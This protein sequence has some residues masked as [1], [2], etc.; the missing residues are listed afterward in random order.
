MEE[1]TESKWACLI[2][3][4]ENELDQ[5]N[6]VACNGLRGVSSVN[7]A[8]LRV[9]S[10]DS[11]LAKRLDDDCARVL[12]YTK[13]PALRAATEFDDDEDDISEG[14]ARDDEDPAVS[15]VAPK[16]ASKQSVVYHKNLF[17]YD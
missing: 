15:V 2:C 9:R 5:I 6:C 10:S 14:N 17:D 1:K 13:P 8:E 12:A 7:P 4:L 3:T 11:E 16:K